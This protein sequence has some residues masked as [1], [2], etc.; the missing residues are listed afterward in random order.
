MVKLHN[1]RKERRDK[2]LS[3]EIT[4]FIVHLC[5][6]KIWWHQKPLDL[7]MPVQ[8]IALRAYHLGNHTTYVHHMYLS[9]VSMETVLMAIFVTL[10]LYFS[11]YKLTHVNWIFL[12]SYIIK[13]Q[14]SF[15]YFP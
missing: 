10:L 15:T 7:L 6:D 8:C 14:L 2:W 9:D 13:N 11:V 12:S 4:K 1:E 5:D 3:F